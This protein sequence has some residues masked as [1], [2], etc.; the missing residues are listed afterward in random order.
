MTTRVTAS[1]DAGP[2]ETIEIHDD[3][4]IIRDGT[5]WIASLQVHACKDG[6]STHVVTIK[7]CRNRGKA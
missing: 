1:D 2:D 3:Y 5:A 6:T 4:V 7:G